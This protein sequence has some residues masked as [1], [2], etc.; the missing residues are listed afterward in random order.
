MKSDWVTETETPQ[1]WEVLVGLSCQGIFN[2]KDASHHEGKRYDYLSLVREEGKSKSMCLKLKVRLF[3]PYKFIKESWW[4]R[5]V[6]WE[7]YVTQNLTW[8]EGRNKLLMKEQPCVLLILQKLCS[9]SPEVDFR[10]QFVKTN[11]VI[12][13]EPRENKK[14]KKN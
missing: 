6:V 3:F 2:T 7:K 8:G 12:E 4:W 1:E 10:R 5:D 14:V 11:T 9:S 13:Q